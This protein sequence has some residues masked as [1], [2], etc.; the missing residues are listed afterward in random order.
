MSLEITI[1]VCSYEKYLQVAQSCCSFWTG[2]LCPGFRTGT[3]RLV[4]GTA[5]YVIK[6][7]LLWKPSKSR[8]VIHWQKLRF[9]LE[10]Q[11]LWYLAAQISICSVIEEWSRASRRSR[12]CSCPLAKPL[13]APLPLAVPP[14]QQHWG[15]GTP[16]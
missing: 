6:C 7:L 9:A 12:R 13:N 14:H 16:E 11:R 8:Q 5:F 4:E 10:R 2:L 1:F 15:N 3:W